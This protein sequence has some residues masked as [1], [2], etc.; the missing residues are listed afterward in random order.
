MLISV[1]PGESSVS[2]APRYLALRFIMLFMASVAFVDLLLELVIVGAHAYYPTSVATGVLHPM[3]I[4]LAGVSSASVV[5]GLAYA[6]LSYPAY[7][8]TILLL[9]LIVLGILGAHLYTINLPNAANCTDSSKGVQGCIMDEVYY[10]PAAQ[11]MLSGEKCAPYAD[12]CNLEHP[13]LSKAFIAAGISIFGNNAIGWRIFEVLLGT[14]SIPLIFGVS[15]A[16]TK[17]QRLALYAAYLLAFETL[18]FVHSSIAVIDVGAIFFGLLGFLFYFAKVHWWKFGTMTLTG[19]SIGV[20]ALYKETAIFLFLVLLLY[21]LFFAPGSRKYIAVSTAK[22]VVTVSLVF[23]VGLQIYD[24]AFGAG[25]ATTFIGQTEFILRYGASLTM[26]PTSQGWIDSVLHTPITPW[27][28]I[29]YYSPIGYLVTSVKVSSATSSYTYV[30]VGYYGIT[31]Q[32]EVWLIYF[33]GAYTV[34]LWWKTRATPM[35]S[36]ADANEF[37]LARLALLWV[38]VV[39]LGYLFLFY[40]G[41][42]T[43]PYYFISAVPALGM[44]AAYFLTR[45]WF[46]REIAYIFL[47]GVFLWFFI[48]YPDKA[49]LPTQVRVWLGH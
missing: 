12:N 41:R 17:N 42:I 15:W 7:R 34:Y 29:T 19:I 4:V 9:T 47:A 10:V 44:G 22:F 28:W 32:F 20:A 33:W 5:T 21:H 27:N 39:F 40:Y 2:A 30:S 46:P 23:A 36:E 43:Y 49:F 48:F 13:F 38:L 35:A 31:N 1:P 18:F 26:T 3:T 16:I 6:V 45:A 25:V 37:K 8:K 14:F 11:T 24:G